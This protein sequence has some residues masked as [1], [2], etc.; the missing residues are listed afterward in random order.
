MKQ[1]QIYN[2]MQCNGFAS[3]STVVTFLGATESSY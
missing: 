3:N 2:F 1:G